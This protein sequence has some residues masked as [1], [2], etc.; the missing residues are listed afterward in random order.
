MFVATLFYADDMAVLAPSVKGLEKM[1]VMCSEYC[2]QWDI[3]LNAKK[4][5]N[6]CFGR[7][8]TPSYK[9]KLN[10]TEIPWEQQWKYLGVTLQSGN[11][12]QCCAKETLA[13]FYR[14]LNSILR[15]DGRSDDMVMLRLLEA[16]CLPIL[17]YGIEVINVSNRD[18][19][20]QLRVAYNAIYRKLFGYSYRESVTN[21]QRCLKRPTWE[22]LI[23][24]RQTKFLRNCERFSR[25][26]LVGFLT[27]LN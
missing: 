26:T 2:A 8:M 22:E 19:K 24:A 9:I 15:I 10:E 12:F 18:D 5:K 25:E 17:A 23:V 7:G 11:T 6:M 3:L 20:R 14:S 1:L 4:S 21:L 16:H 13:K 27:A